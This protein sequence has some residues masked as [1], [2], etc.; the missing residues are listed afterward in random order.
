[1]LIPFSLMPIKNIKGIIHIGAHE[2]EELSQYVSAGITNVLWV[3][4]NPN[5]Q[6]IIEEKISSFPNMKLGQFA[7]TSVSGGTGKL[8]ISNNGQSSSLLNFGTHA[9][10]YPHIKYVDER[11]VPLITVD[12]WIHNLEI[13]EN[14]NI[15]N[16]INLDIQGY[17]LN[18][19]KGMSKQ[20]QKV[21]YVYSEINISEVYQEC[22][23]VEE[24]DQFLLDFNFKRVATRLTDYG[25]GDALYAKKNIF[26]LRLKFNIFFIIS[27][28]IRF[29]SWIKYKLKKSIY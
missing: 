20:L 6:K 10:E 27:F 3:E 9:L 28:P 4:A 8:N 25:W 1:M 14:I 17:E 5:K 2:A 26:F 13:K 16:F 22:P 23:M 7:A 24:I 18:A 29:V 15:Y 12:D 11:E 21:D 19:L